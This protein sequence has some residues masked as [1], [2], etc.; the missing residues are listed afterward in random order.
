M[1]YSQSPRKVL[2]AAYQL[3]LD[4]LPNHY[5][6]FSRH[7]FTLPHLLACLVL[8]QFYNLSYR[9]AENLLHDVPGLMADIGLTVAPDHNTLWR[10]MGKI[11]TPGHVNR[12]IDSLVEQFDRAKLLR[13]S[14]KPLALDSTHFESHH[15]SRHYERRCRQMQKKA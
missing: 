3:A 11:L 12:M 6:K 5:K 10:A 8:R 4:T 13:L 9:R 15:R 1:E 14:E 2:V 7:D